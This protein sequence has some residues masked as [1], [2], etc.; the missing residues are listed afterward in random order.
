VQIRDRRWRGQLWYKKQN[1]RFFAT[2]VIAYVSAGI[3]PD[4]TDSN[5]DTPNVGIGKCSPF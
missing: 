2:N 4:S 3:A 1:G 5:S